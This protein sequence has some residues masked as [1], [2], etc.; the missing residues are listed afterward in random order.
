MRA[1]A[2]IRPRAEDLPRATKFS[3]W[4]ADVRDEE[5]RRGPHGERR[6]QHPVRDSPTL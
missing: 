1:V 4:P 6:E 5:H 2:A 3:R